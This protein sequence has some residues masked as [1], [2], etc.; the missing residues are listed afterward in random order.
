MI[1]PGSQLPLLDIAN[2][3]LIQLFTKDSLHGILLTGMLRT[4]YDQ[5]HHRLWNLVDIWKDEARQ[6]SSIAKLWFLENT[7]DTHNDKNLQL[8]P[9]PKCL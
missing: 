9:L 6:K 1:G 4:A 5:I 2:S 7:N 3:I 8:H